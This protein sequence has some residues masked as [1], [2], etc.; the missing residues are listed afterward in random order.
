MKC[1]HAP[2]LKCGYPPRLYLN[3]KKKNR[4]VLMLPLRFD[5]R[6]RATSGLNAIC[7]SP[8]SGFRQMKKRDGGES[9]HGCCSSVIK[10]RA[11]YRL[12]SS[13]RR[14]RSVP[15]INGSRSFQPEDQTRLSSLARKPRL[16]VGCLVL[17]LY[18]AHGSIVAT[19]L[20]KGHVVRTDLDQKEA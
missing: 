17:E 19:R 11:C 2:L 6:S 13:C 7:L 8:A 14:E 5:V 12:S 4:F 20:S 10:E 15:T 18:L 1:R 9:L 3:K 16:I